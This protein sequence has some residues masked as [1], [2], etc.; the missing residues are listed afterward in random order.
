MKVAL[1]LLSHIVFTHYKEDKELT[2]GYFTLKDK[3]IIFLVK[4]INTTLKFC[5][6]DDL[7]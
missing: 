6:G 1:L 5:R 2:A 4:L 7:I 3:V